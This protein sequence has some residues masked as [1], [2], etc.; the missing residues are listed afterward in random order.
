MVACD[1]TGR[2]SLR[3]KTHGQMK[4]SM[5]PVKLPM[6]PM[7][8]AKCGTDT[9]NRTVITTTPILKASPHTCNSV[10]RTWKDKNIKTARKALSEGLSVGLKGPSSRGPRFAMVN[11]GNESGFVEGA[12]LTYLCQKNTAD[13]HEEMDGD[14]KCE[15]IPSTSWRKGEI[16]EW[17]KGKGVQVE[18]AVIKRELLYLVSPEKASYDKY[19]IDVIAK[20]TGR[21]V[22]RLP[23]Y[24]CELNPIEIVWAQVK[25]YIKMHNVT[26][27][28]SDILPIIRDAYEIVTVE[29][30]QNYVENN[31]ETNVGGRHA[32]RRHSGVG[33][34]T[35]PN[36]LIISLIVIFYADFGV[37]K[38]RT[39]N[40]QQRNS[41]R[42]V[43]AGQ[44]FER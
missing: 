8:M 31:R 44:R 15:A 32:A 1:K 17:L 18:D 37:T 12:E 2:L 25:N 5:V 22:L 27:K 34:S 14:R 36:I 29:N 28:K 35:W 3:W 19:K 4:D 41:R 33:D 20:E 7:R 9:A 42:F 13:A 6:K 24:H 26:F 16:A 23:P 38:H 43:I 39:W 11:A 30:W 21:K 40:I 10:S